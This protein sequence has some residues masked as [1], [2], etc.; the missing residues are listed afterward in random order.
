M[1]AVEDLGEFVRLVEVVA[2]E[3][4]DDAILISCTTSLGDTQMVV[5]ADCPSMQF[6]GPPTCQR[7]QG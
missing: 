3:V 6:V 5:D 7:S 4:L 2:I 1:D